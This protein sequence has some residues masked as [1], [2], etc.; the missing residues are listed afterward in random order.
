[1]AP[2]SGCAYRESERLGVIEL[3]VKPTAESFG[4]AEFADVVA[5]FRSGGA[6]AVER[7]GS[8]AGASSRSML[9]IDA[10]REI[11]AKVRAA[12]DRGLREDCREIERGSSVERRGSEDDAS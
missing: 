9:R 5:A 6:R 12:S 11:V 10:D 1:M 7:D 8:T 4:S 2:Q 3:S